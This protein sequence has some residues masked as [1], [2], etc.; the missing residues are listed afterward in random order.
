MNSVGRTAVDVGGDTKILSNTTFQRFD[1]ATFYKFVSDETLSRHIRN[2]SF[3]F[4]TC[5]YYRDIENQNTRDHLEG[6]STIAVGPAVI[7]SVLSGFNCAIFCGTDSL[8]NRALMERRFGS[9][10]LRIES[11]KSFAD[12]VR[13]KIGANAYHLCAVAY[14]DL[15]VFKSDAV[16]R[17][18]RAVNPDLNDDLF[19]LLYNISFFPSLFAKPTRFSDERELRLVFEFLSDVRT[20]VVRVECRELLDFI[21]LV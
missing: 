10:V 4:G 18:V 20:G 7:A 17:D 2:G 21:E 9:N 13:E 1:D 15:K 14:A 16:V 11:I 8:A 3:Q 19:E 12:A 6:F 5:Q